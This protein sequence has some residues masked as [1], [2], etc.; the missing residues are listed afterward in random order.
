MGCNSYQRLKECDN[1]EEFSNTWKAYDIHIF[2]D[3]TTSGVKLLKNE[4]ALLH[5]NIS[6]TLILINYDKINVKF[7][8]FKNLVNDYVDAVIENNHERIISAF[9][10]VKKV[11]ISERYNEQQTRVTPNYEV[12]L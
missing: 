5:S 4:V 1:I 12:V 2:N 8:T 9:N 11:I 6:H 7:E 10:E 3:V